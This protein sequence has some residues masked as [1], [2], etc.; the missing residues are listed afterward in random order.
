M[1][2]FS[3]S[4][5]VESFAYDRFGSPASPTQTEIDLPIE[6][7]QSFN[8]SMSLT[9]SASPTQFQNSD[10]SPVPFRRPDPVPLQSPSRPPMKSS[11]PLQPKA[12]FAKA[13]SFGAVPRAFGRDMT[14]HVQAN[15]MLA[16]PDARSSAKGLQM[17]GMMLPPPVPGPSSTSASSR[18]GLRRGGLP[19]Q[20]TKPHTADQ[21]PAPKALFRPAI[22]H[23][24]VRP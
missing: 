9:D 15:G 3:S 2:A 14:N 24:D 13:Q 16:P 6:V 7:D 18:T 4:P 8:S 21:L 10:L 19:T 11:R 23:R 22:G 5:L 1:A 12:S 17:K 20:W